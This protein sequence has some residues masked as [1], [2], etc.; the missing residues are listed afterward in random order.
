M[1]ELTD[2]SPMPF[3]KFKGKPMQDVPVRYLNWLWEE[4]RKSG[5]TNA[6]AAQVEFYIRKNLHALQQENPDLIWSVGK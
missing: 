6:E 3:G 5:V 2:L 4:I 1:N